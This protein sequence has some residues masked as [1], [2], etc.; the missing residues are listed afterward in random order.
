MRD[1][2]KRIS[3]MWD[4]G[5]DVGSSENLWGHAFI[6]DS[7]VLLINLPKSG[8]LLP[9]GFVDFKKGKSRLVFKFII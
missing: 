8:G 4:V 5:R 1:I 2:D 6:K 9:P 7:K 3:V